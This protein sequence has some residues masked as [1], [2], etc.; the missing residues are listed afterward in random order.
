MS[1]RV[2]GL[3]ALGLLAL[4]GPALADDPAAIARRFAHEYAVPRFETVAKAA[5]A[6][7]DAWTAFCAAGKSNDTAVLKASFNGLAD[8]WARVEF[9]RIGPA[10]TGMRVERFNWWL[11]RTGATAKALDTMLAAAAAPTPEKLASGSVAGQGLPVIERLLTDKEPLNTQRCAVGIGVAR[12]QAAIADAIVTDWTSANGAAA[13]LD[14]NTRWN[15]SFAD[16]PEAARVMLTDLAAGL[17]GLKDLKVAMLLHDAQNPSAPRFAEA[18]RSGRSW[19]D[20]ELNLAAIREG[21]VYFLHDAPV[22]DS[23]RLDA[24]FD[25]AEGTLKILSDSKL[26]AKSRIAAITHAHEVFGALSTTA[27]AVLPEATGL[28]LGFNNLD[29]D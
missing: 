12:G 24:A 11:D 16:A 1:M 18:A 14:A 17:E 25:D 26:P 5:H 6:Q 21:L 29:G 15:N 22:A 27:I 10:A 20:V 7:A 13:A 3:S 28:T 4:C 23:V 2:P 19:R 9:V 8:A